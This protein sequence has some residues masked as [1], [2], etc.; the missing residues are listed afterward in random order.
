M[1]QYGTN[2]R[3]LE[4]VKNGLDRVTVVT[5]ILVLRFD[6]INVRPIDFAKSAVAL[7]K[8]TKE[9]GH[10]DPVTTDTQTSKA[11]REESHTYIE[12]LQ[13]QEKYYIDKVHELLCED[14]YA[15]LPELKLMSA[16]SKVSRHRRGLG[17]LILSAIPGLITLAVESVSSWIKGKQ[18]R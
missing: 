1:A 12:Y 14:L 13:Q 7:Y 18:Q 4:K 15:A 3:Y 2:F 16:S 9:E 11:A 8:G 5:S 10:K 17:V 6:N